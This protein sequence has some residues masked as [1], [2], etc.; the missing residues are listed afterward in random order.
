MENNMMN[1]TDTSQN[2]VISNDNSPERSSIWKSFGWILAI[3]GVYLLSTI[4]TAVIC[5]A[6]GTDEY[7]MGIISAMA[8]GI[9]T[10]FFVIKTVP[11][12]YKHYYPEEKA[13]K[14]KTPFKIYASVITMMLVSMWGISVASG[15]VTELSG[16]IGKELMDKRI[17]EFANSPI[18]L[19]LILAI[20]IAPI[21]E[22]I[23]FRYGI[24]GTMRRSMSIVVSAILSS[25]I[26]GAIHFTFEALF[27][28]SVIGIVFSLLYEYTKNIKVSIVGHM[29]YNISIAFI[30]QDM[31]D[32]MGLPVEILFV[33]IAVTSFM[34]GLKYVKKWSE[35]NIKKSRSQLD[36]AM[37]IQSYQ[38]I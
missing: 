9:I 14:V 4:I 13:L 29:T 27:Y 25:V 34:I 15:W 30:P 20:F 35:E 32:K 26:F 21:T 31:D 38:V 36:T 5:I 23:V 16:E 17:E 18:L 24:Y 22:E 1:I 37:Q 3:I 11:T 10:S 28:G 2:Y 7:A 19:L 33:I 8:S 6:L 12:W